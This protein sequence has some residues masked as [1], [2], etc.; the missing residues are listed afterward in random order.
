MKSLMFTPPAQAEAL[1][2]AQ[3]DLWRGD[4]P[5]PMPWLATPWLDDDTAGDASDDGKPSASGSEGRPDKR[6]A[7][8]PPRRSH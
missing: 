8:R 6:R 7:A 5:P 4:R 2:D 1:F 3:G